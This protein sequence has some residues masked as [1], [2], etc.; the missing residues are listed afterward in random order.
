MTPDTEVLDYKVAD[1]SLAEWG[2][3][4]IE[5]AE[6]EMPGLMATREKYAGQ[7]PLKGARITGSLHMTIQTA[8]LIETLVD[9]GAEVRWASCN[10]FSTQDHA[11]AAIAAAGVPVFAWKGE[12]LDEYWW[13]TRQALTFEGGKGPNVIVDD[14][15]DATLMIHL[16][17]KIEDN[18]ALLDTTTDVAEEQA[19]FAQLRE[20]F[21][22][23][24]QHW[25]KVAADIKGVSEETTTGVHRLYQMKEKGELLFPAINVNDSV[26][27]SKFDNLYG[28]RESLADGIKRA[29]DVMIAGKVLVVLGYGDVGKGCAHSM[30]SYGARVIVTEIDPICALQ[31]SMEG[32][33]VITMEDAVQEGNIFVTT[34]GNKDVI[35]LEHMKQM[36]DEAIVCNIGH[37]D[38]EIQV[39]KLNSFEGATRTNIKPQVDKYTFDDG[40]S[41]YLLAEGRL[42]NLG[43]ATGH[44]SFVMSNSFTN[45][46]LAQIELWTKE[47]ETDVF[48]LPKELD[49]E[50]A[51]L[52]LG[53]LGVKLTRLS[54]EQADY[55]GVPVDGPYKPEHYRY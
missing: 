8:V 24:A 17:Y 27:K 37:F 36:R 32:F 10:I 21:E 15:G 25:H 35:T 40:R 33:E 4:E 7:K 5:I 49:E 18:P 43:C 45:Q 50:V 23:D 53:Q 13:C 30:R 39:D 52:H 12:T 34:T 51:R 26:T 16:G 55:I 42:V 20:M 47:Y 6:K 11:A 14:G 9:L 22:S 31:A 28:C 1:I 54:K 44:P 46:T 3:K 48:R 29:T 38:N 19:L 2:R 41:I